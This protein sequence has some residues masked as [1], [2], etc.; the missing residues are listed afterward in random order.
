M[1]AIFDVMCSV[2]K[3]ESWVIARFARRED[4]LPNA[5]D[6]VLFG[7]RRVV[8]NLINARGGNLIS[9][10][11]RMSPQLSHPRLLCEE[12]HNGMP[13]LLFF[14]TRQHLAGLL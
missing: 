11:V 1:L 8:G 6:F 9:R 5:Y 12:P 3:D 7:V 10:L 2:N 4:F 14:S 13:T